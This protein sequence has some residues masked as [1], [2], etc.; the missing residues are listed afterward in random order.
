MGKNGLLRAAVKAIVDDLEGLDP[1][2]PRFPGL[3]FAAFAEDGNAEMTD[4]AR[5]LL[6]GEHRP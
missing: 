1:H 3:S 2:L 6:F 4:F 5:P